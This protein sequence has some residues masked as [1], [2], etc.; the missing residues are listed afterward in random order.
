MHKGFFST[1]NLARVWAVFLSGAAAMTD[2]AI[3]T[4]PSPFV[5][6]TAL[7]TDAE[8]AATDAVGITAS[9]FRVSESGAAEYSIPVLVAPGTA[10][11]EPQ[12]SLSYNSQAGDG[13]LG[14]GWSLGG[15]G[16]I[17][18]CRQT[19]QQDGKAAPI[20]WS[21]Q[22][23]FCL[24]GQ[25][26]VVIGSDTYGAYG[27][28]YKTEIDSFVTVTSV[29]G[30]DGHPD[31]FVVT[32]KDGSTTYYGAAGN[33]SSEKR[34]YNG[35]TPL[36]NRTLV[37]GMSR[38]KDSVGNFMLFSYQ[39]G[40][41]TFILREVQ[42]AYGSN[43]SETAYGAR[44][45]LSYS[46]RPDPTSGYMDGYATS[47]TLR[48][49][50]I[51]SYD[52]TSLLRTYKLGYSDSAVFIS[53]RL[54]SVQECVSDTNCLKPLTLRWGSNIAHSSNYG[55]TWPKAE[56][57][58]PSASLPGATT[59]A[60]I[61]GD[62]RADHVWMEGDSLAFALSGRSGPFVNGT[63]SN[64]S[65][66]HKLLSKVKEL[67][68]VDYN[69]D[70]AQDLV[71]TRV[72]SSGTS[73]HEIFLSKP[74]GGGEWR[75]ETTPITL[76]IKTALQLGDVNA[77]GL[78]DYF[79]MVGK[80][81]HVHYL[82][83]DPGQAVDSSRYYHY[84]Q[85]A[86]KIYSL[87]GAST[88]EALP[89]WRYSTDNI[90][91]GDFN[92]DGR[93]DFLIPG[94][95]S[96][97]QYCSDISCAG[98]QI[99]VYQ[100][101]A[102]SFLLKDSGLT[103]YH[104]FASGQYS[105]SIWT[106]RLQV[107]D[108]NNDGI[109]DIA[110][111]KTDWY[112]YLNSGKGFSARKDL[113]VLTS[114]KRDSKAAFADF[115]MNGYADFIYHDKALGYIR[116]RPWDPKTNQFGSPVSVVQQVD[117]TTESRQLV[118]FNGDG[119]LDVMHQSAQVPHL[120]VSLSTPS[121]ANRPDLMFAI[122]NSLAPTAIASVQY[123]PLHRSDHYTSIISTSPVGYSGDSERCETITFP[124]APGSTQVCHVVSGETDPTEFYR[125]INDPF[126]DVEGSGTGFVDTNRSVPVFELAGSLYVVTKA[127]SSAPVAGA[128]S[129]QSSV[130]YHYHQGRYQAGGRGFLGFKKLT[131]IDL[132]TGVLTETTFRQDWPFIGQPLE[133]VTKTASGHL[134]NQSTNISQIFDFGAQMLD[135]AV[136][137][138]ALGP[139]QVYVA[140]S[141][142]NTYDL[143]D[144][145]VNSGQLL[146][147]TVTETTP[148][149]YGNVLNLT[150]SVLDGSGVQQ[151]KITTNNTYP[152]DEWDLLRGRLTRTTVRYERTGETAVTRTSSFSY[153][154][155]GTCSSTN[156]GVTAMKLQGL[157]CQEVVEPGR[158]A[159]LES[160][161]THY[162]DAF[163]N[164]TFSA[165]TA[166]GATRLSDYTQ[167]DSRGRF[168]LATYG[169]F[170]SALGASDFGPMAPYL[171][172]ASTVGASVQKTSHVLERNVYGRPTRVR[173]YNGA[174]SY[175][176]VQSATTPFGS[177]YFS[178][179]GTGNYLLGTASL[180]STDCPAGTK[181]YTTTR[182]AGGGESRECKDSSG[183]TVREGTKGFDGKWVYK[184]TQYDSLGRVV[185]VSEPF[186]YATAGTVPAYWTD[187]QYDILG[188]VTQTSHPF[189]KVDR[190]S[191]QETT[192]R[193]VSRVKY[194]GLTTI[195]INAEGHE[196]EEER[197][198]LGKVTSVTEGG[199]ITVA[200]SYNALGE[201]REMTNPAGHKT[202]IGFDLLGRKTR[203]NDPSKGLWNYTYNGFGNVVCQQNAMLQT[204]TNT[205]DF[206]GRLLTR[207][208][209]AAG[210][211][212]PAPTGAITAN[213]SWTYDSAAYGLGKTSV[214][215][216]SASTYGKTWT[217]DSFGR[218][219]ESSTSLP[220]ISST[221]ESHY[222]K[223]TFDQFGRV[224]Q[225]F[226]AARNGRSF[227]GNG[228]KHIYNSNGYLQRVVDADN[229]AEF[230]RVTAMDGR[231]NLTQAVMGGVLTYVGRYNDKS[232]ALQ[233]QQVTDPLVRKLQDDRMRWDHL[234]NLVYRE[235]RGL[236]AGSSSLDLRETFT[237]DNRNQLGSY[238]VR[239]IST[240][241]LQ[242]SVQMQYDATGNISSKSDVGMYSYRTDGVQ[243]YAVTN[244]G[245][246]TYS[247]NANG[248]MVGDG[249]GRK[250]DYTSFDMVE[251]I[252]HN[253]AST[254]FFY[255]T[256]RDRYKRVDTSGLGSTT[257]LYLGSV[258]K[259]YHRDGSREWKRHIA[260]VAL[261]THAVN[262]SN[263]VTG[264]TT[265]YLLKDHLGSITLIAKA[266]G[267]GEQELAFDPWGKRRNTR[268]W[269]TM[270]SGSVAQSF[271]L[272]AKPI[273]TRGFTGH[274]MV[275]EGGLIHMNGRI[276]DPALGRFL[277]ADPFIQEPTS[278]G[279]LNRYSYAMNNPLNATDPSGYFFRKMLRGMI[280][281]FGADAVNF[282]GT[283]VFAHLGGFIG[284][285]IWSY[286][287][288]RA[289][290]GSV[291]AA[292][293]SGAIS[294]VTSLAYG[295]I[296]GK[297]L[298][299]EY[300]A[301][302]HGVVGG[303]ESVLRGGKFG[304]GFLSAG[305]AK[306]FN[307]N[308]R[309]GMAQGVQHT[310][311]RVGLAA[312]IGGTVS[313][314]TGGK[315]ANGA[316]TAAMAQMFNGEQEVNR[317]N[318]QEALNQARIKAAGM[319]PKNARKESG[320]L[321][322]DKGNGNVGISDMLPGGPHA[323]D[324]FSLKPTSDGQYLTVS[325][326]YGIDGEYP[327]LELMHSHPPASTARFSGGKGT[328]DV[329]MAESL[330][331][332]MSVVHGNQL[333]LYEPQGLD[334]SRKFK[335][336][337]GTLICKGCF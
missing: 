120:R 337:S 335:E 114:G 21:D 248:N 190:T 7:V 278:I 172:L 138:S 176:D 58:Y 128:P 315:F 39:S 305:V 91:T 145:G 236:G 182:T 151:S 225:I 202:V 183:R 231:G 144:N 76:P 158:G 218:V 280:K 83:R 129:K 261:V 320:F 143:V 62:G 268:D 325:G 8:R 116:Y 310:A 26:L 109:S 304:H 300:A 164:K 154:D 11:V 82:Q 175:V 215:R 195:Y 102:V 104:S 53:S 201:L 72:G 333:R 97:S 250:I 194:L 323:L 230:Y 68:A 163:G 99:T 188:R 237:Y 67:R 209:R 307:V 285:A 197:D 44:V 98:Q 319:L 9:E 208:D 270:A 56:L 222:G 80:N 292:L 55:A 106:L 260:G 277:Q 191:G 51:S 89:S 132:Q 324:P 294:F 239:R 100:D 50:S 19:L 232:G 111:N 88:L 314:L 152:A 118:D 47:E 318:A 286:Q 157:L 18:R 131:T 34:L 308:A 49:S 328:G 199:S 15:V 316:R 281:A 6:T 220:G 309:Y 178:A 32:A 213:A 87:S 135:P 40:A 290:G 25:R 336:T 219:A 299:L 42:Y 332:N 119:I 329:Y 160:R 198:V 161:T 90:K 113:H 263:Q 275:D 65:S 257:T 211:A 243:P 258:E 185:R 297:N 269:K 242:T 52:G 59:M 210:G 293:K 216:D 23:R 295:G 256:G 74:Y 311:A 153:Y 169:T 141:R 5:A 156:V 249:S 284:S 266:D 81:L 33:A 205:Y 166:S 112:F 217:Y 306:A 168:P 28:S 204:V 247:Y 189:N 226:D 180:G 3:E 31:S 302:A 14:K 63:F 148:D 84:P 187:I 224:F 244:A 48:L 38:F 69:A 259:V 121:S 95:S 96:K 150:M 289:V 16:A 254:K 288:T 43:T 251:T 283:L 22:D 12:L 85:S 36:E 331:I 1:I 334:I 233:E 221:N 265:R 110:E 273:T 206:N 92:G 207:V 179:D 78:T 287:F 29:G 103:Y 234:G 276:Y 94:V 228:I 105:S 60:D 246:R 238:A 37:W 57:T 326:K 149:E 155:R 41:T 108:L 20:T 291:S 282:F 203:M 312:L 140:V 229:G 130:A 127:N 24:D 255:G 301:A 296:G 200:Y 322:Y 64:G 235:S 279:S 272:S 173:N 117:S 134:L 227:T 162:Y 274:E 267:A 170:N 159:N 13:V 66:R 245:G 253:S 165:M 147:S 107:V 184:D 10:G 124:A 2:A 171:N 327:V 240:N 126:S 313:D 46:T 27:A 115:N 330:N 136:G 298:R 123:K 262:S 186:V 252:T 214:E 30:S 35:T 271:F 193:A 125:A 212:C 167:F 133:T 86:S 321:L 122:F 223:T 79:Y 192:T 142:D 93:V 139:L 77:D 196:K 174:T 241:A 70:G 71:V 317:H 264:T 17:T 61:N 75:L 177:V 146:K 101:Y 137:T 4:P 181:F 303:I 73:I 54:A 45:V